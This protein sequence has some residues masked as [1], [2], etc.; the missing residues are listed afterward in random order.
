MNT[1]TRIAIAA[2]ALALGACAYPPQGSGDY[3]GL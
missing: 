1:A 3:H 2:L